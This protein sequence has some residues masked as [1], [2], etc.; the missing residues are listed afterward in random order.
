MI[1]FSPSS[2]ALQ[3]FFTW[4][5][6]A[7]SFINL[8]TGCIILLLF[9]SGNNPFRW[10]SH[11]LSN[12]CTR[13]TWFVHLLLHTRKYLNFSFSW[14]FCFVIHF[15]FSGLRNVGVFLTKKPQ[16]NKAV[17]V[18]LMMFRILFNLR[19]FAYFQSD[20]EFVWIIQAWDAAVKFML[21]TSGR[22]CLWF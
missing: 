14:S 5:L 12:W 22:V 19:N 10:V 9:D 6:L 3:S 17:V 15:F 16:N 21:E 2:P 20:L 8:I 4:L 13:N 1:W 7:A 18:Y 11:L